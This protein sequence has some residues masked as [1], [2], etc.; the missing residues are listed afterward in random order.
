MVSHAL[1]C[2]PLKVCFFDSKSRWSLAWLFRPISASFVIH[3]FGQEV[4][5]FSHVHRD[6]LV[7]SSYGTFYHSCSPN[8]VTVL[9]S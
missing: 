2:L 9:F 6:S 5:T 1:G 4:Y 7:E 3:Y 8:M